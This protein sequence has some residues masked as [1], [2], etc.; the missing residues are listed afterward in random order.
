VVISWSHVQLTF[1]M[2]LNSIDTRLLAK[3]GEVDVLF[4]K[5]KRRKRRSIKY[6]KH[7][8]NTKYFKGNL[9]Q[10]SKK[11][12][13]IYRFRS[14]IYIR[15]KI[16]VKIQFRK[17]SF[18]VVIWVF[19]SGFTLQKWLHDSQFITNFVKWCHFMAVMILWH[20]T[21]IF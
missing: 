1:I 5:T 8:V 21:S 15:D 3:N 6:I 12:R 4:P 19:I 17:I 9:T 7:N 11:F 2:Q 10:N 16:R 20:A 14:Y 13:Y 18:L